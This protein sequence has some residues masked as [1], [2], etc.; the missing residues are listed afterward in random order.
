MLAYFSGGT[1]MTELP[2][3]AMYTNL[4]TDPLLNVKNLN[5]PSIQNYV[6]R[7]KKNKKKG[8][9]KADTRDVLSTVV[10]WYTCTL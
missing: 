7:R 1:G 2:L 9:K 5:T 4:L 8:K 3:I 6:H 10:G